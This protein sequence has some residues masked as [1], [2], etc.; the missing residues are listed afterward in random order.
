MALR[1]RVR[2]VVRRR[3]ARITGRLYRIAGGLAE[4]TSDVNA[5]AGLLEEKAGEL[6]T[7]ASRRDS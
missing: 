2:A 1:D 4:V 3:V 7:R 5:Y 6:H